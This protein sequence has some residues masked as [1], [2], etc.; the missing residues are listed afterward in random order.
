MNRL[1]KTVVLGILL[2]LQ[3]CSTHWT[4]PGGRNGDADMRT[5]KAQATQ[6]VCRT[7]DQVSNSVC[8]RWPNGETHCQEV[9][10]PSQTL[11]RPEENT[12]LTI[13]CFK[14]LGW[15]ETDKSSGTIVPQTAT[16]PK[17]Q[18]PPAAPRTKADELKAQRDA[19]WPD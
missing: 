2:F 1:V 19:V 4:N 18:P 9:T 14:A 5:C 17:L 3:G 13:A 16:Y 15:R 11:C 7:T 6:N 10:T 12:Q 8:K